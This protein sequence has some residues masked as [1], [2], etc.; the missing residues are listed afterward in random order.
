M[1]L[2]PI[3]SMDAKG[4]PKKCNCWMNCDSNG[5]WFSFTLDDAGEEA[6]AKCIGRIWSIMKTRCHCFLLCYIKCIYLCKA[7][8]VYLQH[9]AFNRHFQI[10]VIIKAKPILLQQQEVTLVVRS[11]LVSYMPN[12]FPPPTGSSALHMQINKF[13]SF[14]QILSAQIWGFIKYNVILTLRHTSNGI[15]GDIM[16]LCLF[17]LLITGKLQ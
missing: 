17:G 1:G 10:G 2:E 3:L 6:A 4:S 14:L 7:L 13:G 12:R 8:S 15:S 16:H 11:E 9:T 5:I